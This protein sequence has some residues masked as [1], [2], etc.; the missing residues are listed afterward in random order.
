MCVTSNKCSVTPNWKQRASTPTSASVNSRK[1]TAPPTPEQT[2]NPPGR[3]RKTVSRRSRSRDRS[4]S[5]IWKAA[6]RPCLR[7]TPAEAPAQ[8]SSRLSRAPATR[9]LRAGAAC[10][11]GTGQ[12]LIMLH[13]QN[14][15]LP[16]PSSASTCREPA[17][18][19]F[20]EREFCKLPRGN[21]S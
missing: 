12:V 17:R 18:L 20:T 2:W 15:P 11:A 16:P 14:F 7:P 1:S 21:I 10:P 19:G 5:L 9:Q 4:A 6:S 3:R 8:S 13:Y